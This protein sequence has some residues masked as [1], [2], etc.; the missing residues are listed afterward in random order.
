MSTAEPRSLV[1]DHYGAMLFTGSIVRR[2]GDDPADPPGRVVE[3]L[4]SGRVLVAWACGAVGA[5]ETAGLRAVARPSVR[6]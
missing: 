3:L 5:V 4:G 6:R 1:L 2:A